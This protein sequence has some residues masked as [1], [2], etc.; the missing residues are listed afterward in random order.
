VTSFAR[1][2]KEAQAYVVPLMVVCLAPGFM[3]VMPGLELNWLLS[4]VPLAN[5]VLLARDVL[6][7]DAPLL[8]GAVAVVSTLLYGGLALALAARV[9]GSDAILYGSEG[10]WGDLFR[11]PRELKRQ[12]TITDALMGLALVMPLFIIA[13]GLLGVVGDA[14]LSA[15]LLAGAGVSLLIFVALPFALARG[16]AVEPRAGFQLR[17]SPLAIYFSAAILGATLWPLAY[18]LII[19]CR[20]L[21]IATLSA[22]RIAEHQS[23]LDELVTRLRALPPVT[24][25]LTL[26]VVPAIGEEFF[27]RGYLLGALRGRMPAWAAIGLV[28]FIFG[29]FHASVFGLVAIERIASSTLLGIALG[30]LCWTTRSVFP[31]MVVHAVSNSMMISLMYFADQLRSWGYDAESQRYLPLPLVAITTLV[32]MIAVLGV[33]WQSRRTAAIAEPSSAGHS[34]TTS[35]G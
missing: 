32:A 19:L 20:D 5:I 23:A 24:V 15:R 35:A 8:W 17:P 21:G 22:Q 25:L 13:S 7:G 34:A 18:D 14:S 16:Q 10:S 11:R 1:S 31:G 9:F 3:S 4:V 29:L 28:G 26:A 6:E 12:P 33:A 2:F 27:F 30:W